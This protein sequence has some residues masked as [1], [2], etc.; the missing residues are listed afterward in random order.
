MRDD[1]P[2]DAYPLN[3][4]L[5]AYY[6]E[7]LNKKELEGL[8]FEFILKHHKQFG[9]A[10]WRRDECLD[11]V[12]WLY[13]RLSKAIDTYQDAGASFDA[14]IGTIVRLSAREYRSREIDHHIA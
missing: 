11:Y 9:L 1:L 8:I 10:K 12:C 4:Y 6:Q 13:P 5:E 14:Y 3:A 2:L 7:R